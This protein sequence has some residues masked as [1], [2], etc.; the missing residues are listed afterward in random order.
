[1]ATT[2][3]KSYPEKDSVFFRLRSRRKLARYLHISKPKLLSLSSGENLYRP[4]QKPKSSGGFREIQAPREDLKAVQRRIAKLLQRIEKASYLFAPVVGKSYVDNAA[5]HRGAQS[6]RKLDIE[7]FF[8]SCTSNRVFWFFHKRMQ[9]SPDVAAIIAGIVTNNGALPQGSP[10][11]PILAYFSYIDMWEE[12]SRIAGATGECTLSVYADDLTISGR[13][14]P[15]KITWEIRKILRK[16][17]HRL[18]TRKSRSKHRRP[19]EITGAILTLEGRLVP[20]NRS[21]KGLHNARR[22]LEKITSKHEKR[23]VQSQ[24]QGRMSQM[25]QVWAGNLTE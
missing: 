25:N 13:I 12:I 18:C 19:A 1:M 14:V 16:Y 15:E 24:I 9:C 21:H 2:A 8:P 11:S 23:R 17:G 6:I 22:K 7:D 4:F 20:P 3:N 10:C 5:V